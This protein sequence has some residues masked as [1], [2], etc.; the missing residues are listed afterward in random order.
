MPI[1]SCP[2][3]FAVNLA[4][5]QDAF[6]SC[7]DLQLCNSMGTK[8]HSL[9]QITSIMKNIVYTSIILIITL[10]ACSRIVRETPE[11]QGDYK[12]TEGNIEVLFT[13]VQTKSDNDN[14]QTFRMEA[15][16]ETSGIRLTSLVSSTAIGESYTLLEQ[17]TENGIFVGSLLIREDKIVR[18]QYNDDLED[19]DMGAPATKGLF[20]KCV[21]EKYKAISDIIDSDGEARLLC[22][23][24]NIFQLCNAA[25][26]VASAI[27]CIRDGK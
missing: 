2:D 7:S 19:A 10:C 21:G 12:Y 1:I 20:S 9:N 18:V 6:P 24:T 16:D 15:D 3:N 14:A 8:I 22:D 11:T 17:Y 4:R 27:I 13:P 25:K 5:H 23:G 26:L